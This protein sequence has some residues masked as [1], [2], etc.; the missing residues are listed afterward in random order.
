M[1]GNHD[2]EVGTYGLQL[3]RLPGGG[4][5]LAGPTDRF[6]DA[7]V[8]GQYQFLE[9]SHALTVHST[10]IHERQEWEASFPAGL[11]SNP[12]DTLT[13][14]RADGTYYF[15]RRVGV[16]LGVFSTTGDADPLEYPAGQLSGS[17]TGAPD[18]RG[19]VTEL[20]YSPWQNTRFGLQWVAYSKFNGGSGQTGIGERHALRQCVADVVM[21]RSRHEH[22]VLALRAHVGGPV[23]GRAGADPGLPARTR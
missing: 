4:A 22:L 15:R 9:G 2:L 23:A 1:W 16:S 13:T 19:Y 17:A 21:T 20:L 5:S 14:V 10:W 8:D 3:K 7:A 11:V 18:T 6:L 12:V